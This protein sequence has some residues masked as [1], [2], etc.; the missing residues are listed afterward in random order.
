VPGSIVVLRSVHHP[1]EMGFN[2]DPPMSQIET[3]IFMKIKRR[4]V[5]AFEDSTAFNYRFSVV[6]ALIF[7]SPV[8]E[9][10]GLALSRR[11]RAH[12]LLRINTVLRFGFFSSVAL[13]RGHLHLMC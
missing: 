6:K 12:C 10:I 1:K 8:L 9:S 4:D 5:S 3:G 11:Y 7:D 13:E 2:A